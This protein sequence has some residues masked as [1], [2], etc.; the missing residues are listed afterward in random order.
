MAVLKS[1]GRE[2]I[3]DF[4]VIKRFA[5]YTLLEVSLK[6]GRTHQIRVHLKHLGYPIVGDPVYK[7]NKQIN[8]LPISLQA[9]HAYKIKFIHPNG[10][11][12]EFECD[13]PEDIRISCEELDKL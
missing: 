12:M 9:L 13:L 11:A 3:S 5:E 2:A 7:N 8:E 10:E 6:T 4:K 1:G